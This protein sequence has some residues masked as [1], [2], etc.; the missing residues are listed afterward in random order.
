MMLIHCPDRDVYLR[1]KGLSP[2]LIPQLSPPRH[3]GTHLVLAVSVGIA[4]AAMEVSDEVA[5][6]VQTCKQTS[7]LL[8][9]AY[10]TGCYAYRHCDLYPLPE[11]S[12][13]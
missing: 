10:Y 11:Y 3:Q 13:S 5:F 6:L 12:C 2:F 8:H 4:R 1:M 7:V 9:S